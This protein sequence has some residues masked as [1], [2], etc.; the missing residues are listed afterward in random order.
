MRITPNKEAVDIYSVFKNKE[1]SEHIATPI[2]I[3]VLL[4]LHPRTVLEMGGGIG[5]LT[6]T[7][8]SHGADV[9]VYEDNAYCQEEL[10]KNVL[11][12]A[13]YT[14]LKDYNIPP[15]KKEYDLLIV[16]GATGKKNDGGSIDAVDKILHGLD[17]VRNVYIEGG[18]S[19]QRTRVRKIL[20][21]N[22]VY[23]LKNFTGD[24]KGGLMIYCKKIKNPIV[25]W[26]NYIFWEIVEWTAIKN[27]LVYRFRK[28]FRLGR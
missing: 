22:Y 4:K 6:H 19:A 23:T 8:A 16:D 1:G 10:G 20:K 27:F 25:R 11:N 3:E 15:P 28:Y 2:S 14:L 21:N 5:T 17:T 13:N 7:L 12:A 24:M 18:R 9:D 26:A